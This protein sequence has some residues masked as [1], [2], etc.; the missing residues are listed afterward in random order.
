MKIAVEM[1]QGLRFKLRSFGIPIEGPADVF[2]DNEAVANAA[3]KPETTLTKKHNAVAWHKCREAA[4]MKMIRVAWE[5]TS[6]NLAD[7]LTKVKTKVEREVL[8]DRF[9]Y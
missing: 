2:F 5:D 7:L 4:A 8:I 1:I 9:M 3:R 6:I